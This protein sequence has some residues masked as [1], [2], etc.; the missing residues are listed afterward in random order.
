MT[1]VFSVVEREEWLELV[2]KR[3]RNFRIYVKIYEVWRIKVLLTIISNVKLEQSWPR[4]NVLKQKKIEIEK[5]QFFNFFASNIL[6]IFWKQI[7]IK[8]VLKPE[9]DQK[10]LF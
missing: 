6:I 10:K 4:W 3:K 9:K 7:L 1:K 2:L 8:K 5:I